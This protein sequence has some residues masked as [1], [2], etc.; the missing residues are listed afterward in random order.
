MS[1][2]L[3]KSNHDGLF[4]IKYIVTAIFVIVGIVSVVLFLWIDHSNQ[5]FLMVEPTIDVLL[6]SPQPTPPFV[7]AIEPPP[8]TTIKPAQTIY[9][10]L[11]Q[12]AL[13]EH[14]S[15][16]LD[17]HEHIASQTRISIDGQ[18]VS[19]YIDAAIIEYG[20][21]VTGQPTDKYYN[22]IVFQ[23][24]PNQIFGIRSGPHLATVETTSLSGIKY[25]YSWVFIVS[26]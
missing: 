10:S 17:L 22:P 20:L 14:G 15:G 24:Q 3:P 26:N 2:H 6:E 11:Y 1:L 5:L 21:D 7:L 12:G 9:L 4:A 25:E 16:G 18:R 13:W 19:P 23:F 8:E